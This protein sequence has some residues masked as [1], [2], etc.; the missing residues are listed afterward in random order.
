VSVALEPTLLPDVVAQRPTQL[1]AAA[2]VL[3]AQDGAAAQDVA[4]VA[5]IASTGMHRTS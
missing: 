2:A 1:A 3:A 5:A 4:V